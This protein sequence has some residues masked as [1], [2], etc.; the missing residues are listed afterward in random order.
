[1]TDAG[2]YADP[3]DASSLR[4]WDGTQWTEH[5][6]L[7]RIEDHKRELLAT[8]AAITINGEA[9]ALSEID[10]VQWTAIR[11]H[12]NGA[13]MGTLFTLRVRAGERKGDFPMNTGSSNKRID[14]YSDAYSC[15]VGLLDSVVCPR[16]A[17][18]MAFRV[19]GGETVTL[20]PAGARVELTAEGFRLKKPWSKVVPWRTVAATELDGGRLYFLLWKDG[21][22][23]PKR[24]SMVPLDG[25]NIVVLPHL[26]DLMR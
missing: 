13:Y 20:G 24:H 16:I 10:T 12:V 18:D 19:R 26:V 14:E 3:E 23:E 25:E 17:A 6:F 8:T 4:W 1:M 11:S 7:L 2:W 21:K 15:V 9:F 22:E 5:R